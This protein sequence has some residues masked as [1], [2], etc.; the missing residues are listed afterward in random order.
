MSDLVEP[1]PADAPLDVP[2]RLERPAYRF[3]DGVQ[4][5]LAAQLNPVDAAAVWCDVLELGEQLKVDPGEFERYL[6]PHL[7]SPPPVPPPTPRLL[8]FLVA[9]PPS[10][11]RD[12]AVR[13]RVEEAHRS[14]FL[15][16]PVVAQL[17]VADLVRRPDL[18][19]QLVA[20]VRGQGRGGA[21]LLPDAAG[22]ADARN[23]TV[24]ELVE[25]LLSF[26]EPEDPVLV[27]AAEP[28]QLRVVL[29]RHPGLA[30]QF[31]G[32]E[33]WVFLPYEKLDRAFMVFLGRLRA[34]GL[35]WTAQTEITAWQ[36]LEQ[37]LDE[38]E[39]LVGAVEQVFQP[40]RGRH[41]DRDP[42]GPLDAVDLVSGPVGGPQ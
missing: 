1:M 6:R 15:D 12:D 28:D 29:D 11:R 24:I 32:V 25:A 20:A 37:R 33:Q 41:R 3:K 36:L 5:V 39:D 10:P 9:G 2:A 30:A 22:L 17:R 42:D 38:D 26:R 18:A 7:P 21:L 13:R 8:P 35:K 16:R 4:A 34:E 27:L 14:R 19:D 40:A 23:A 31:R